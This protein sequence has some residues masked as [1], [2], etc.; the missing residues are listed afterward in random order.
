MQEHN[1]ENIAFHLGLINKSSVARDQRMA[2]LEK[3]LRS[4]EMEL[5][6]LHKTIEKEREDRLE[7]MQQYD[8]RIQS[9]LELFEKK[10]ESNSADC[11]CVP[12]HYLGGQTQPETWHQ[13]R[14]YSHQSSGA[15]VVSQARTDRCNAHCDERRQ[16][17]AHGGRAVLHH[18]GPQDCDRSSKPLLSAAESMRLRPEW[19][20]AAVGRAGAQSVQQELVDVASMVRLGQFGDGGRG[21]EAGGGWEG[22]GSTTGSL[23]SPGPRSRRPPPLVL[24]GHAA[25]LTPY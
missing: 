13:H 5:A 7:M 12:P 15:C 21:G 4:R 24:S 11:K 23:K 22:N 20:T 3:T 9:L 16:D 6:Q 14:R 17:E 19:L 10:M 8:D 25:S 2:V 1:N 18:A